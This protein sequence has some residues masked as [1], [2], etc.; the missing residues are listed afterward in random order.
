MAV[1]P[2]TPVIVGVGQHVHRPDDPASTSP[3][4]LMIEAIGA[5]A[6]DAGLSALPSAVDSIRVVSLLSYRARNP[7]LLVAERLG[8]AA[9]ETAYTTAGGNSPQSLVNRTALDIA[10]GR[11]DLVVLAGAE[12][13]RTRMQA[14]KS[15]TRF[16][17][18]KAPEDAPPVVIGDELEMTHPAETSKG[19]YLPVQVYPMFETAIRA[20]S[21]TSPDDHLA[22]VAELWSRFSR[23][24]AANP[25]AWTRDG[26][27]GSRGH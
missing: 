23:V 24:A 9:A 7:A 4:D 11:A 26:D 12:A 10:A 16:E 3:V 6:A 13:W 27:V 2:R 15:G 18:P 17:W 22:A 1:D 21:G 8:V 19:I 14:R 5:A 20:A 25:H